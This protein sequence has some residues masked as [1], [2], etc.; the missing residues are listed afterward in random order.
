MLPPFWRLE[1]FVERLEIWGAEP[2]ATDE[3]RRF[4]TM[5]IFTRFEDPYQGV[6]RSPDAPNLWFG[7]IPGTVHDESVVVCAY[8]IFESDRTVRCDNFATLS[9]P[10]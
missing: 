6:E 10:L 7:Q 8:W 1:G 3:L 2:D 9:L 5:W 4:V